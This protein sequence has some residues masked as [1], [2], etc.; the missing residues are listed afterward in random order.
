VRLLVLL[1]RELRPFFIIFEMW[2]VMGEGV[3][4]GVMK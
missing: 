2:M 3:K 1:R 4:M